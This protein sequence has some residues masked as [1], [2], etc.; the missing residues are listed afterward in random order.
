MSVLL[1]SELWAIVLIYRGLDDDAIAEQTGL[2]RE[3][4]HQLRTHYP[5]GDQLRRSVKKLECP[6][7]IVLRACQLSVQMKGPCLC[8]RLPNG[9]GRSSRKG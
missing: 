4:I 7:C 2:S 9:R 5:T 3:A 8:E 1:R 6:R